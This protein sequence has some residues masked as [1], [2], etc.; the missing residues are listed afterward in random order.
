[1]VGEVEDREPHVG[2]HHLFYWCNE[3]LEH[4]NSNIV[5]GLLLDVVSEVFEEGL[6]G[7]GEVLPFLHVSFGPE[8]ILVLIFDLVE[9]G[10]DVD[11]GVLH[12]VGGDVGVL[13][14]ELVVLA[15]DLERVSSLP[16]S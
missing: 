3:T 11:E 16:V 8:V 10:E 14:L 15:V 4:P 12:V 7:E 13:G 5:P 2:L 1:M 6:E 9:D